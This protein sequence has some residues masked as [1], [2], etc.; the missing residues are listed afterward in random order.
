MRGKE[1]N[2]RRF[3]GIP[4]RLGKGP[5][6]FLDDFL[7][8]N[9]A[10]LSRTTHPPKRLPEPVI[11]KAEIWH[12]QPLFFLKVI[13]YPDEKLFRI[14][15]NVRNPGFSAVPIAHAYAVSEDGINWRRPNLGLVE[16]GGSRDN[17][18]FLK[19][20]GFGLGL[21]DDGPGGE[22]PAQR[23]KMAS[24]EHPGKSCGLCVAFSP[25]GL[26]WERY[27]GNPVL[28]YY[29]ETDSRHVEAVGDIINAFYDPIR[30]RYAAVFS[31]Y[32]TPADGYIG[33]SRT[34]GIRRLLGQSDSKDF[35]HWSKPRRILLPD[36]Q[37]DMTEFYGLDV[38]V[39]GDLGIGLVRVLRDDL[40]ADSGGKIEGIGFTQ[41]AVSRDGE[42]WIRYPDVFFDRNHQPGTWDHAMA[43]MA[44]PVYVDDEMLFYYG[45]Y[46]TGHK[47]GDRQIGLAKLPRDRYVSLDAKEEAVGILRTP[48]VILDGQKMKVNVN[49]VGGE[50][51][52][53]VSDKNLHPLL[54]FSYSDCE[55]I[56]MDSLSHQVVW[57]GVDL[58]MGV[59]R[60]LEFRMHNAELYGFEIE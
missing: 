35:I 53:Q 60:H 6:L 28:R 8:G 9:Q 20:S 40:S 19:G 56:A 54:G 59:P 34:G 5:H 36:N 27:E 39:R 30:G 50:V 47:V 29:E 25:D 58:P 31:M 1:S 52:V 4:I 17:N 48:L 49:A 45:G 3:N 11:R 12:Q 44:A 13:H 16:T 38:V 37:R 14:W 15:Y 7:V 24:F 22:N 42:H 43:W 26:H 41:L 21:I 51:R 55:P 33:K 2:D 10:G 23:F 57:K 46:S 32:A 18:L